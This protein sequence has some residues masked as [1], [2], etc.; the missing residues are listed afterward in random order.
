MKQNRLK[1]IDYYKEF[2]RARAN[3]PER[4][5]ARRNYANTEAGKAAKRRASAAYHERFPL[6]KAA[7]ILTRNAV[8]S[9][10]LIKPQAYESCGSNHKIEAHHDDYTKPLS[11]RWLCESCHKEWHRHN[12]P[13]YI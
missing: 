8:I 6:K 9:G 13:V 2:D 12:E 1:N 7:H 3:K 10:K 5:E 11:V 4:V